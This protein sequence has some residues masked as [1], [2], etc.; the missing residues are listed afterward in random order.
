VNE[1]C[2]GI[3]IDGDKENENVWFELES[4]V[5]QNISSYGN[6]RTLDRMMKNEEEKEDDTK[7][8]WNCRR[9]S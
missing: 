5:N 2:D 3:R 9:Y 7:K 8:L 1:R 4:E 6:N